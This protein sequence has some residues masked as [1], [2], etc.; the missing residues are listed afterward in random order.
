MAD[1][2]PRVLV[3]SELFP[4]PHAPA[5]GVFVERQVAALKPFCEQVVVSPTRVFPHLR[6]W[7]QIIKPVSF[8]KEWRKWLS[9]L[10]Q[11]P[12]YM[13]VNE[14]PVY[15]PRYTSPPK[16]LIHALWGI[17]AYIFLANTLYRLHEQKSF[18]LIHA[19]YASPCGLIALFAKRKMQ[20]PI[21]LSIHGAD[22][23]YT[24]KQGFIGALITVWILK[25]VDIIFANSR[26]TAIELVRYGADPS[27]IQ[28]VYLGGNKPKDI[29][30]PEKV[31][32]DVPII[33]TVGY[34]ENHKGQNYVLMALKKLVDMGYKFRYV[35]VGGG[36]KEVY[37]KALTKELGLDDIV[38]F[39]GHKPHR[40]VWAYFNQCDIFVLP[41]WLEAFGVVYIEALSFGKPVVGCIGTG[42]PSDL[43][44]FGD[45]VELVRQHNVDDIVDA[46]K[47]LLDDP[48]R[49]YR[50]GSI[51]QKIVE[52]HF[53]WERN[54]QI[55]AEVYKQLLSK[56][57]PY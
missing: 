42:G 33:L 40:D 19:H 48:E 50:M 41:S 36:T 47:R 6:I 17:F 9:E 43:K 45:C 24:I 4:R 38:S 57:R 34:L 44:S 49:R 32:S 53:T 3:I 22:L 51:G 39:E 7:K 14:I 8:I 55:T 29:A 23:H 27:K 46:L 54:A 30:L 21:A 20:V 16:Q 2:K 56:H 11:T 1:K 37:L 28:V 52:E 25:N 15:Y 18:D 26:W 10:R 12:E 31:S 35:L 5:F 13:E